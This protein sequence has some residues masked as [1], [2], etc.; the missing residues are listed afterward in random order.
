MKT[1][2]NDEILKDLLK[3]TATSRFMILNELWK[4]PSNER[5]H[6]VTT[7]TNLL[8]ESISRHLTTLR[9][10]VYELI[11]SEGMTTSYPFI[12]SIMES[13]IPQVKKNVLILAGI[14][15]EPECIAALNCVSKGYVNM[16]IRSSSLDYPELFR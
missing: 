9:N 13:G 16:T 8:Q 10:T 6:N 7:F 4:L 3:I 5:P 2:K 11:T 14:G 1:Q 15:I 12:S